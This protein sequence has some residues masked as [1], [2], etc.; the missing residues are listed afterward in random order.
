LKPAHTESI[1]YFKLHPCHHGFT[2]V[3]VVVTYIVSSSCLQAKMESG[4]S[5]LMAEGCHG[6]WEL[7]I[8]RDNHPD[9]K[10]DRL[11]ALMKMLESL[12]IFVSLIPTSEESA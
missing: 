9:I 5:E 10:I 4:D 6:M 12:N 8:N 2:A 1:A 7:A 3:Q 11:A